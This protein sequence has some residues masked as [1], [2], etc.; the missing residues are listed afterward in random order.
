MHNQTGC[1][2]GMGRVASK[3]LKL[4]GYRMEASRCKTESEPEG[5]LAWRCGFQHLNLFDPG[6]PGSPGS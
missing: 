6:S 3:G 4:C 1:I 2:A 5:S